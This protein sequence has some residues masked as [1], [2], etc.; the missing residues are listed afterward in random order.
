MAPRDKLW[1]GLCA[2]VMVYAWSDWF[3][4]EVISGVAITD[5]VLAGLVLVTVIYFLGIAIH[6]KK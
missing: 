6:I 1:G 4:K 5:P 2:L 3:M